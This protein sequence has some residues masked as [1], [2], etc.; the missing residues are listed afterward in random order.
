MALG[1]PSENVQ[2]TSTALQSRWTEDGKP[3][4]VLVTKTPYGVFKRVRNWVRVPKDLR[5]VTNP[6]TCF[7]AKILTSGTYSTVIARSSGGNL[8]QSGQNV[9]IADYFTTLQSLLPVSDSDPLL[10]SVRNKC[11]EKAAGTKFES[12]V[13]A[14]EAGETLEMM[15]DVASR[16]VRSF[17]EIRRGRVLR[18]P[19]SDTIRRAMLALGLRVDRRWN[20]GESR[21]DQWLQYRYGVQT[22]LMDVQDAAEFAARKMS[23]QKEPLYWFVRQDRPLGVTGY[24]W[25]PYWTPLA[26]FDITV[27]SVDRS[28]EVCAWI[29]AELETPGY[30]SLQQSGFGNPVGVAWELIPGSF[31]VDW[32]FGIGN[33]LEQMSALWGLKVLDSGYSIASKGLVQCSPIPFGK[34]RWANCVGIQHV[35]SGDISFSGVNYKRFK[36]TNPSPTLELGSGLNL[37]RCTDVAALVSGFYKSKA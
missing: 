32:A 37:Q 16:I 18:N 23:D 5:G 33:Y 10:A 29:R 15:F 4:V 35:S 17:R 26:L 21:G 7:Q 28:V 13:F 1:P 6:Y 9:I 11:L 8:C 2:H 34:S 22:L 12:A 27:A 25:A 36:W 31:L 24:T 19:L 30:R 20:K 14:A 3:P